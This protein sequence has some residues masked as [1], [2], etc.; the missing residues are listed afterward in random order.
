MV[1]WLSEEH[2]CLLGRCTKTKKTALTI[3]SPVWL[4]VSKRLSFNNPSVWLLSLYMIAPSATGLSRF[5]VR[6][7]CSPPKQVRRINVP[8]E[9]ERARLGEDMVSLQALLEQPMGLQ[10]ELGHA[11]DTTGLHEA[12]DKNGDAT[13]REAV[14]NNNEETVGVEE[15][16]GDKDDD[17]DDHDD[18]DD[19]TALEA[20]LDSKLE[21]MERFLGGN[22]DLLQ[23]LKK[24]LVEASDVSTITLPAQVFFIGTRGRCSFFFLA[25]I[26]TT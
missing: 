20:A 18:D 12:C 7:T 17:K 2:S 11:G 16:F 21:S 6:D 3:R 22:T 1:R 9:Q 23:E 5:V 4:C 10:A 25:I 19:T 13:K 26:N 24:A 14:M 8:L 15:V